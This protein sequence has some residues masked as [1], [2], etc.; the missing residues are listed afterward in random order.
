MEESCAERDLLFEDA[1]YPFKSVT[2]SRCLA[3]LSF[4][5]HGEEPPPELLSYRCRRFSCC[6]MLCGQN[7][8]RWGARFSRA[9]WRLLQCILFTT[10]CSPNIWMLLLWP[11]LPWTPEV[12]SLLCP[13]VALNS[14]VLGCIT[15]SADLDYD[16]DVCPAFVLSFSFTC[17]FCLAANQILMWHLAKYNMA[18]FPF[19]QLEGIMPVILMLVTLLLVGREK[20]FTL[21]NSPKISIC[22]DVSV[23][24][25]VHTHTHTTCSVIR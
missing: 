13:P 6:L 15:H 1:G 18:A 5:A 8:S 2:K 9:F 14:L 17:P 11:W 25:P 10:L 7:R 12:F 23:F 3:A 20:H 19:Q 24:N 4:P 22:H 21:F 16:A